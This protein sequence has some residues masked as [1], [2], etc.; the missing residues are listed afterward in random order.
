MDSIKKI[1]NNTVTMSSGIGLDSPLH[2][3][4]KN[5]KNSEQEILMAHMLIN[6]NFGLP[7]CRLRLN[8]TPV[9]KKNIATKSPFADDSKTFDVI[10]P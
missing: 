2:A 8:R 10:S 5:E 9:S 1:T 3:F 4:I 7:M 6:A